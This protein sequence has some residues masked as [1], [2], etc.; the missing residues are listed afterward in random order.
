MGRTSGRYRRNVARK[1][2]ASQRNN[3]RR[4]LGN[5][6][7][8]TERWPRLSSRLSPLGGADRRSGQNETAEGS[9]LLFGQNAHHQLG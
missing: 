6:S 9:G 4:A 2:T 5:G 1:D 8:I 7:R 3:Q